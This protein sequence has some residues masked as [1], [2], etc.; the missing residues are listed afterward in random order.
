MNQKLA[1][2]RCFYQNI[3]CVREK[4]SRFIKEQEV[5]K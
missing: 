1:M 3:Q 5:I 4:K 2:E